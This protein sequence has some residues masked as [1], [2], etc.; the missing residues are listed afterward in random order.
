MLFLASCQV[1]QA[2]Q[3]S[4]LGQA[5]Q[6]LHKG[7]AANTCAAPVQDRQKAAQQ[8]VKVLPV[9]TGHYQAPRPAG[10]YV[11][12]VLRLSARFPLRDTA[13]PLYVLYKSWKYDLV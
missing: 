11:S 12:R 8:W 6:F 13:P 10:A 3:V 7:K 5:T 1:R 2:L 4:I 9:Q